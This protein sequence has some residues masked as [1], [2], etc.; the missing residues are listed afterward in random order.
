MHP[1]LEATKQ[2][3]QKHT[4]SKALSFTFTVRFHHGGR[5]GTL[6]ESLRGLRGWQ[7]VKQELDVDLSLFLEPE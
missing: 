6:C 5:G 7:K 2:K 3:V 4:L 1:Q